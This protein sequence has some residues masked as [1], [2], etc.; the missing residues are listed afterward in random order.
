MQQGE[1]RQ[2]GRGGRRQL[3]DGETCHSL[4]LGVVGSAFGEVGL[5]IVPIAFGLAD[6]DGAGQGEA[7]QEGFDIGRVLT[8]G[9]DADV[10]V[11]LGMLVM[12]LFEP[13]LQG[14]I[15]G[16]VFQDGERLSG[17]LVIGSTE[18][19]PMAVACGVD[20]NTDALQGSSSSH[21]S[22]PQNE[23]RCQQG[24]TGIQVRKRERAV[25][26]LRETLAR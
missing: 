1:L 2:R 3:D 23:V 18:R 11:G 12:E 5:L 10:E 15:A 25:S 9:V 24:A 14:A 21:D 16:P 8:G 6:G 4:A 22:P 7:A 19:N 13:F 26:V 20:A 17:R